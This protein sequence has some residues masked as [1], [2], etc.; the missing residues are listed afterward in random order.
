LSGPGA[1][2]FDELRIGTSWLDVAPTYPGDYNANSVV[3]AADYTVW[4]NTLGSMTDLRADGSGPDGMPD[5]VIDEFDYFFWKQR[6]GEDSNA[7]M[8]FGQ[9][10]SVPEPHGVALACLAAIAFGGG[11]GLYPRRGQ[12]ASRRGH[13]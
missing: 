9:S 6:Y 13:N 5:Q 11:T 12:A 1:F 2:G 7:A 3:D 8:A 4:R 10:N